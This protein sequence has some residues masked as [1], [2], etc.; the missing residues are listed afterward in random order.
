MWSL[1]DDVIVGSSI[2][3][4]GGPSACKF[5]DPG[6]GGLQSPAAT[7]PYIKT[8]MYCAADIQ[9]LFGKGLACGRCFHVAFDGQGGTDGG[10]AGSAV[11]QVVNSGVMNHN[12]VFDC[13]VTAFEAITGAQTGVYPISWEEVDCEV[14]TGG[15]VATLLR[16]DNAWYAK[17]VFS[18]LPRPATGAKLVSQGQGYE[19]EMEGCCGTWFGQLGGG[20]GPVE[21]ELT[22]VGGEVSSFRQCF[23]TWPAPTSSFCKQ[24]ATSE[25]SIKYDAAASSDLS[26]AWAHPSSSSVVAGVALGLLATGLVAASRQRWVGRSAKGPPS[27][28]KVSGEE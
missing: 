7:S 20:Q 11:I 15:A 5:A 8:R 17:L 23:E 18:N 26:L 16:G 2:P 3:H 13:Q 6:N 22:L 9:T 14:S 10:R 27:L 24:Q 19:L 1:K 12:A 21:L 28:I 25:S 4:E